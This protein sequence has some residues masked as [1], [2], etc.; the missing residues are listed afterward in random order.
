[1]ENH[2]TPRGK[3]RVQARAITPRSRLPRSEILTTERRRR[4]RGT[5]DRMAQFKLD[6][7]SPE[8]LDPEYIYRWVSEEGNRLRICTRTDDYDFVTAD[9][10]PDF[11][12]ED[13]TDSEPGGRL[14]MIVGER[15]NGTP[16]Y[17]FLVKKPRQFWEQ[18]NEEAMDFRDDMLAGRVYRAELN[19]VE[20]GLAADDK[21]KTARV[22]GV[23][24]VREDTFYVPPEVS[25]EHGFSEK[26]RTGPVQPS[27]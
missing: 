24:G 4:R 2:I 7:F 8:Q 22:G 18:D 6:V 9:E 21:V 11:S 10:I 3:S 23:A 14:R 17:A 16:I 13:M 20:I 26:A 25:A 12:P 15:K 27:K 1:M 19:D 5:L